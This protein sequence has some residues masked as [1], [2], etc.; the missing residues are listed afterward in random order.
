MSID[1]S[2]PLKIRNHLICFVIAA[3]QSLDDGLVRKECAPLVSISIWHN[4]HSDGSR[5]EIFNAHLRLRKVWRAAGRKYD[6][7]DEVT[8]AKLRFERG[9]LYTLMVD[10]LNRLYDASGGDAG[11]D[12][13][14]YCERFIELLIDFQSQLPTR[15]YV[16]TLIL[17]LHILPALRLSPAYSDEPNGLLRDLYFLLE[18]Y[19]RF[20]IADH[21]EKPL[22]NTEYHDAHCKKL[23]RLQ[24]VGFKKFESKLKILTLSNY[25]SLGRRDDLEGHLRALNDE[26][27]IGF[28][29]S[30]GLRTEYPANSD[31]VRDRSFFLEAV[32]SNYEQRPNFQETTR[33]LTVLPTERILY[34]PAFLRSEDY[35]GSRP[36]AMPKLN[37]QY[38]T[39]GDFLWR[40]FILHRCEAFHS[41]RKDMEDTIKRL[42]PKTQDLMVLQEWLF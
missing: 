12:N 2:L 39:V 29:S 16:N 5:E 1:L 7:A 26:E 8:K 30:L 17:D 14:L 4:L 10:F 40:S 15:R 24:R 9:W 34:E 42:Q 35:N 28:C 25:G 27:L 33:E 41:I 20:P 37:L 6:N 32:I 38:L 11:K 3:F 21:E 23:A 19:T 18:H 31:L 22:S 13:L 36:L